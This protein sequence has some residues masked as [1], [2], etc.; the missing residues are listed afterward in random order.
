[1]M[2]PGGLGL[3]IALLLVSP[4]WVPAAA[5][6]TSPALN[7][8]VERQELLFFRARAEQGNLEAQ[9]VL[10]TSYLTGH[11]VSK[12][13]AG[14]CSGIEKQPIKVI[15]ERLIPLLGCTPRASMCR[16]I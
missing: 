1:M 14:P 13:P 6:E 2:I 16:K 9:L 10:G 3:A 7:R 12:D 11:A 15:G 5:Q 8:P 4:S